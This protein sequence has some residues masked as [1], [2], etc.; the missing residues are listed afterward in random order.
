MNQNPCN[1]NPAP[2]L[3]SFAFFLVFVFLITMP[4][5]VFAE[6]AGPTITPTYTNTALPTDTPL[7]TNTPFIEDLIPLETSTPLPEVIVDN[8]VQKSVPEEEIQSP[9]NRPTPTSGIYGTDLILVVAIVISLIIVMIIVVY[10]IVQ[11]IRP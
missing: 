9:G 8:D 10:G 6:G 4:S 11:R 1:L 5:V 2:A 3:I 7:P